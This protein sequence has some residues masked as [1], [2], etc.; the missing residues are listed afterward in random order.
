M[1]NMIQSP[2]NF[3]SFFPKFE[4]FI[5]T[6]KGLLKKDIVP[7]KKSGKFKGKIADENNSTVLQLSELYFEKE[8][9]IDQMKEEFKK[10]LNSNKDTKTK[11]LGEY[12]KL[13]LQK[14]KEDNFIEEKKSVNLPDYE[15]QLQID[16]KKFGFSVNFSNIK[17][18]DE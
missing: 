18:E 1:N 15:T 11:K 3:S 2:K 17:F 9:K 7:Y 12:L 8:A 6:T 4:K 5:E 14:K 16:V 13:G 10:K